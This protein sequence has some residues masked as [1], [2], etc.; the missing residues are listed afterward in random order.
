[1]EPCIFCPNPRTK[2][3]GEHVWDD[4]LNREGGKDIYDPSTT[5]YFGRDGELLRSH[6]SVRMEVT[7]PVVCD[8]CNNTWMSDLST[9][10]KYCLEQSIRR[11]VAID[12]SAKDILVV[13]AFAFLKSAVLDWSAATRRR[14]CLSRSAC[15]AFRRSLSSA[16]ILPNHM[17]PVG[18]QVWLARYQR[19]HAMEAQA[20]T[21]EMTGVRQ[22]KGYRI[23]VVTY[24]V[25]SLVFQLLYPRWSK[26]TRNR[27]SPPFFHAVG[28]RQ[29]VPIW[30]GVTRA[31]WPPL[32][33]LTGRTLEA[34]RKRFKTVR[35]KLPT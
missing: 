9:E 22:F 30:P 24:A 15:L 17:F 7:L 32:D 20:F 8:R 34:F 26:R 33:H 11:D 23:L 6:R 31:F 35:F 13:T 1:M 29:S 3:R 4:W 28:D 21:D 12:L 19:T 25:G 5:Y 16:V 14:P 18:L 10:A 2:K 27:P